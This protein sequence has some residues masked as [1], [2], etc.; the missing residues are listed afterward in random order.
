MKLINKNFEFRKNLKEMTSNVNMM[1][2]K[3]PKFLLKIIQEKLRVINKPK[4]LVC[5]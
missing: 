5:K 3:L 2:S 1:I 4:L